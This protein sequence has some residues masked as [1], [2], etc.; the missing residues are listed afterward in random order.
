MKARTASKC[1]VH[2]NCRAE[3]NFSCRHQGRLGLRL[4]IHG[5]DWLDCWTDSTITSNLQPTVQANEHVATVH[6]KDNIGHIGDS[7]PPGAGLV[8]RAAQCLGVV[9][10]NDL[11]AVKAI[12]MLVDC[13]AVENF[14]D[15]ELI[16]DVESLMLDYTVLD[17]PKEIVTARQQL[18]LGIV[19]GIL[20]GAITDKV[21]NKFDVGF[22][23]LIVPRLGRN[24]RNLFFSDTATTVIKAVIEREN[25]RLERNEIIVPLEQRK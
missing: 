7:L 4:R 19:T 20:P 2:R 22:P 12:T 25:S 14:V 3:R 10:R 11:P 17:K 8:S 21:G 9:R 6:G 5:F 16:P 24:L 15:N 18:L 13:G 1:L 23:S